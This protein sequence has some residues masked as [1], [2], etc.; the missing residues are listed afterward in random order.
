M[1]DTGKK[2]LG[3]SSEHGDFYIHRRRE[4]ED[5]DAAA[6]GVRGGGPGRAAPGGGGHGEEGQRDGNTPKFR[7]KTPTPETG[8]AHE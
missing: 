2:L 5:P 8:G 3:E 6:G 1:D 7:L 4:K